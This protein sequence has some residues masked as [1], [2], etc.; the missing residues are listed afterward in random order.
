M[1]MNICRGIFVA[2]RASEKVSIQFQRKIYSKVIKFEFIFFVLFLFVLL[3]SRFANLKTSE[4]LELM[5]L[6]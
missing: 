1:S 6:Q 4:V 2:K 3:F 5:A